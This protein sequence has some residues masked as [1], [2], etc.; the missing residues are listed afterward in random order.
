MADTET[1]NKLNAGLRYAGTSAATIFT[2]M[3][4]LA[5]LSPDQI[6][7]LSIAVH[8]LNDSILSAYG[9]LTKMWVI[10]GPIAALYL[11]KVG[12]QSSGVKAI[13]EKLLHIAAGPASPAAVEAQKAVIQV[14]SAIAQDKSIPASAEATQALIAATIALPQVQTI[15]TDQKTA[16][17]APSPSVVAAG[18]PLKAVG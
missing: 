9:A 12:V 18:S 10:L 11:G 13:A 16:D 8:Q 3:G 6:A 7:Q 5:I 14:T 17:A 4:A 15:V 1:G 2:M